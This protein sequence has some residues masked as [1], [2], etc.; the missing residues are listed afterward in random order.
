MVSEV[1][2]RDLEPQDVERVVQIAVMAWAPIYGAYRQTLGEDLFAAMYPDWQA[3]K[4][5]QVRTACLPENPAMVSV[6]VEDGQVVGF[7]TYYSN[8]ASHV[9]EIGNN[10][11]HPDWQGRGIGPEMYHHTFQRLRAL[12]MRFVEVHTG[13]DPAHAPARRAYEKAG[14]DVSLPGV[15]YYRRL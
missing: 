15:T 5:R 9:G 7:I 3:D 10:A 2:V 1:I 6:A 4:A 12:G 11:V 14:F 8:D 13:G